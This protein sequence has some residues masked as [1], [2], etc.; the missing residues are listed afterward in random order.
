MQLNVAESFNSQ[1][2]ITGVILTKLDGDTRGGAA[3]S[4]KAITG[5]PIKFVGSGEKMNDLEVFY[6]DRMASRIL[7]MGDVLSLIEK[8]QQS[9]DENEAKELGNRMLSQE[10]NLDDF[11]ASMQQMKKLGPLNK[12]VEMMP[13]V[14]KKELQGVDLSKSEKD[15][16]KVEAI[17]RSMTIAERKHPSLVSGSSSR[18]KRIANGSGTLV[19][20]VNKLLKDFEMMKKFMKQAKGFQKP[21]KKGLFGKMPF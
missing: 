12:L 20:Q 6:P 13:G 18:K 8:A 19:Q 15:M 16:G 1:L 5:K 4:I 17:I 9:I 10:F 2:E 11:L 21:G 7:G 14:N 3:L